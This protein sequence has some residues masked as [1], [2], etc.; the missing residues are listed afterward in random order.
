MAAKPIN[1]NKKS[2]V[3]M[4]R[5]V[6]A[7]MLV[8]AVLG[9]GMDSGEKCVTPLT[10]PYFLWDCLLDGPKLQ[11]SLR[12]QA[13]ID[14]G[15]HVVLID[16][17]LVDRL[18]LRRR[19]LHQTMEVSVALQG[20]SKTSFFLFEYVKLACSSLDSVWTSRVVHALMAPGLCTPLLLGGPFL[21][22]NKIVIDHQTR[23][24]IEKDDGYDLLHP[25][26]PPP[27]CPT[28]LLPLLYDYKHAVVSELNFVLPERHDIMDESCKPVDGLQILAAVKGQIKTLAHA[29]ELKELDTSMKR[30]FADRFPV[31][32]LH[33]DDLLTD[34]MY[35][36]QLKD[37]NKIIQQ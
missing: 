7:V 8:S 13:L 15:S 16:E 3:P 18:G 35:C 37:A 11:S 17:A 9:E 25:P 26:V 28:A 29:E 1:V 21:S 32:I 6:H 34:V 5:T 27:P 31:D 36:I 4:G 2:G 33:I 22:H 14:H 19:Q 12:V 10:M 20:D 30:K 24:C 23:T